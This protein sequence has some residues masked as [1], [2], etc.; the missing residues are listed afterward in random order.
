V[1]FGF[2]FCVISVVYFPSFLSFPLAG[3]LFDWP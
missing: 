1:Y 2:V 3:L